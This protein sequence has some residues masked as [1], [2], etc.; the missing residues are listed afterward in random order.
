MTA[1]TPTGGSVRLP[2]RMSA[3]R[4]VVWF[5]V[6]AMLADIV[7]EGARSITGPL[8]AH[9][10]AS[11][12]LVGVVT[13]VGES[14]ALVLR[15]VS[16]PLA[17]RT[18]RFWAWAI[19]GYALTVVSVPL[20]GLTSILWVASGLVIAER[21]GKA[22]RSPAKDTLLSH[23]TAVTGRGRGFAVHEVLDQA[24]A[25]AGPL[26][27][28]GVLAVTGNDYGPA[29]FILA[30]PGALTLG[31]L[32]WL[33]MQVPRPARYE[34]DLTPVPATTGPTIRQAQEIPAGGGRLPGTFWVYA[35]FAGLT[36]TGFATFGVLSFHLVTAGLLPAS[37]VPVLYAVAMVVDAVA[38]V[39]T[40]WAYDR[41]GA[42]ALLIVPVVAGVIPVLA[43]SATVAVAVAGVLAWGAVLGVQESTLKATVADL[44]GPGR[45]ATA[46]GVFGAV[47]G[48]AAAAGGTLAGALY[49]TSVPLLVA[50]TAAVQ[51]MALGVL[52]AT[53]RRA[54]TSRSAPRGA[55]GR[56]TTG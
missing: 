7:Y 13:G 24:G 42:A 36:M 18:G 5:G 46:Y 23:A 55:M 8:L 51:L 29:L 1:P 10:G 27:V 33:R 35:T 53:L 41:Y 28:A 48:I 37:A 39:A 15:L 47:V 17:D 6:V 49:E 31:L 19:V 2:G 26:A 9:L 22:V 14:A 52:V 43:F 34:P 44:V 12:L 21:V 54:R 16:G 56:R 45:R 25:L 50:V 20:L 38:A 30:V 40:G 11:A 32:V 4:F 3:W